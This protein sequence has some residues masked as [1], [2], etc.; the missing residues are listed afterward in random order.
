MKM[1]YAAFGQSV[2]GT[3]FLLVLTFKCRDTVRL[4]TVRP[5]ILVHRLKSLVHPLVYNTH[6]VEKRRLNDGLTSVMLSFY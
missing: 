2:P 1:V 6:W 5:I 3:R 4:T